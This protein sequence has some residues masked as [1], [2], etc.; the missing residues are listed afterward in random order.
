[1]RLAQSNPSAPFLNAT[2]RSSA[3][4]SLE[5]VLLGVSTL[6]N[7]QGALNAG[8]LEHAKTLLQDALDRV[9]EAAQRVNRLPERNDIPAGL[10]SCA[11]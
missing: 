11:R 3:I 2:V 5:T 1:M 10:R 7:V 9:L 8:R 6:R 4:E